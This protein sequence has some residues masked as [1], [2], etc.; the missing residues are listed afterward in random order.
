MEMIR[1]DYERQELECGLRAYFTDNFQ[2]HSG[3]VW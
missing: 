1:H 3:G 2:E